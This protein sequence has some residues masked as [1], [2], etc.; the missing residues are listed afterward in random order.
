MYSIL[1]LIIQYVDAKDLFSYSYILTSWKRRDRIKSIKCNN[2][3]MPDEN[4]VALWLFRICH[5]SEFNKLHSTHPKLP[6]ISTTTH[7]FVQRRETFNPTVRIRVKFVGSIVSFLLSY[8]ESIYSFIFSVLFHLLVF[9]RR[10][11][12][13]NWGEKL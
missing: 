5:V 3:V 13:S 8:T 12:E 10:I 9:H 1:L 11:Q 6:T 2:P 7:N 4:S